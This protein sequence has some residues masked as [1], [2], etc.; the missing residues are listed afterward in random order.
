M[1]QKYI[2][3]LA[4]LDDIQRINELFIQMIRYV[5][6]QN[7]KRGKEFDEDLFAYG[8]EEGFLEKFLTSNNKF[9]LV[10]E[11]D[12]KVVGYI[13]CEEKINEELS[14]IYLDDFCVDTNFRGLGIGTS[15]IE[16][17]YEYALNNN[18]DSLRLHVN[19]E[20]LNSLRFYN[21]L[22]FNLL[23][24]DDCRTLMQKVVEEK[25]LINKMY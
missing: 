15:L 5:N 12:C 19:N 16:S 6:E 4:T 24:K 2:I 22:G 10:A 20:N 1:M 21:H 14:F 18:Y 7:K 17:V 9:I 11:L 3:R 25:T 23:I 8:Y 13:S